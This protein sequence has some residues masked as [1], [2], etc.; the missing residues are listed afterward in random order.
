MSDPMLHADSHTPFVPRALSD[1][2]GATNDTRVFS[3]TPVG[4]GFPAP[5][6]NGDSDDE[7]TIHQ[8]SLTATANP[9]ISSPPALF[10]FAGLNKR[11]ITLLDQTALHNQLN[12]AAGLPF[13]KVS[14][15]ATD[16]YALITFVGKM[17]EYYRTSGTSRLVTSFIVSKLQASFCIY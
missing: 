4:S 14:L 7:V 1:F 5:A 8:T 16:K 2:G 17:P 10:D 9:P 6:A 11:I 3:E 15:S 12:S 13:S